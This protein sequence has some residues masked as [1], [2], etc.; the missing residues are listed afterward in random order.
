MADAALRWT[1]SPSSGPAFGG[2]VV[3]L[4]GGR[5]FNFL[6][7]AEVRMGHARS[8][9]TLLD[10]GS[11]LRCI[12]PSASRA[13]A[14]TFHL[15]DFL[16]AAAQHA[17]LGAASVATDGSLNLTASDYHLVGSVVI[18]AHDASAWRSFHAM[19]EAFLGGGSGG[20]GFSFCYGERAQRAFGRS[21]I[22]AGLCISFTTTPSS[23]STPHHEVQ[24]KYL[25]D[26]LLTVDVSG[27]KLDSLRLGSWVPVD[28]QCTTSGLRVLFNDVVCISDFPLTWEPEDD[29]VFQFGA[30]TGAWHDSHRINRVRLR[31]GASVASTAVAVT[32]T[33]NGQQ[34]LQ[35]DVVFT[36]YPVPFVSHTVPTNGPVQGGTMIAL[37]GTNLFNAGAYLR[38]RFGNVSA[39]P[40]TYSNRPVTIGRHL[41]P[42]HTILCMTPASAMPTTLSVT[43]SFNGHDFTAEP[44]AEFRMDPVAF[45]SHIEPAFGPTNGD[46]RVHL[47]GS[48]F[49][50]GANSTRLCR[51]GTFGVVAAR[52][53]DSSQLLCVAPVGIPLRSQ[54]VR[55]EVAFNGQDFTASGANYTFHRPVAVSRLSPST[56]PAEGGTLIDIS[57]YF[58]LD[59]SGSSCICRF[60]VNGPPI[61]AS[62]M[63][64]SRVRCRSHEL[65]EGLH[66]LAVSFNGQDYSGSYGEFIA[67]PPPPAAHSAC[68]WA[69]IWRYFDQYQRHWPPGWDASQVSI[70]CTCSFSRPWLVG[71]HLCPCAHQK[72]DIDRMHCSSC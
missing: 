60:G 50:A 46:T 15:V 23:P 45:V 17:L 62:R 28:I 33:Y 27:V 42:S 22:L 40:A 70:L 66:L 51:F 65:R 41:L 37:L 11:S 5:P 49:E 8:P 52:L 10:A 31:V 69:D 26:V 48:G 39:V 21:G 58:P 68:L 44:S 25:G 36:F 24:V 14:E 64:A 19:F 6:S 1:I 3:T 32:V 55:L 34:F 2:T 29:W 13:R 57:G 12:T 18:G 7:Q 72:R 63:S 71:F 47:H 54:S 53:I 38:C 16:D 4:H 20:E 30:S 43:A 59:V 9:A 35:S 67:Y 61:A 56:G